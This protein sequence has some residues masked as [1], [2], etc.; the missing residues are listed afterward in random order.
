MRPFPADDAEPVADGLCRV[1]A[2]HAPRHLVDAEE[3]EPDH[4][5]EDEMAPAAGQ[6]TLSGCD[7]GG[8]HDSRILRSLPVGQHR[9]SVQICVFVRAGTIAAMAV[10]AFGLALTGCGGPA[11]PSVHYAPKKDDIEWLRAY[12][13]WNRRLRS[14][15]RAAETLRASLLADSS[16][17]A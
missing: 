15:V 17:G 9:V 11:K 8:S 12:G 14:D 13:L 3:A 6:V 2:G 7:D 16:G 10:A 5:L 1:V 4:E